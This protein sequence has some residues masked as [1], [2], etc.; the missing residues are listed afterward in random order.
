MKTKSDYVD[1]HSKEFILFFQYS[2]KKHKDAV[3]LFRINRDD[4]AQIREL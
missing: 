1:T 3:F 4:T 2:R